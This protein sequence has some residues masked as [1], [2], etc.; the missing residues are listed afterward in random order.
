MLSSPCPPRWYEY[1]AGRRRC[2]ER[3]RMDGG[4][5][6]AWPRR[7]DRV[8]TNACRRLGLRG[9]RSQSRPTTPAVRA[10]RTTRR[11]PS[12]MPCWRMPTSRGRRRDGRSSRRERCCCGRGT[13]G[14]NVW[15]KESSRRRHLS[16]DLLER[17]RYRYRY[18]HNM[19]WS[20]IFSFHTYLQRTVDLTPRCKMNVGSRPKGV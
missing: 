7:T 16:G 6:R 8:W 12:M 1:D 4:A 20:E 13:S 5:P 9:R 17:Y 11:T 3:K 2:R 15:K 14:S 19:I 18:Q 10:W